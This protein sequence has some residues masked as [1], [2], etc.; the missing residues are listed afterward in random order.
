M[1]CIIDYKT[2]N[3]GSIS[4][5]L[6]KLQIDNKIST[7]IEDILGADKLILPGVGAFDTGIENLERFDL[8][9][10]INYKVIEDKTPILGICLGAQLL[11]NKSEEGIRKGFSL[12]DME[13]IKFKQNSPKERIPNI[14]WFYIDYNKKSKLFRDIENPKYYFVHSYYFQ[15]E[16]E[17]LIIA[18]NSFYGLNY[19]CA[20]EQENV[21]G[22]QF[23][24]EKSHK[25][26]MALLRNFED[27]Y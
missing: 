7:N 21:L 24:P 26:G 1:I 5:M 18:Q 13:I 14:G 16:L 11:G 23:H 9:K 15:V 8:N 2:G 22:V 6:T 20:F 17:D 19:T 10:T 3:V 25:Y 27:N 4:N 12:I